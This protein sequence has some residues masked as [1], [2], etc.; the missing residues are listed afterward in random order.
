MGTWATLT[1]VTADSASVAGLARKSLMVFHHVDSLM[2]NWTGAS[3]VA[4]INREA[5]ATKIT[6]HPEVAEVLELAVLVGKQS[7][8][9]FDVTIEPLVRLWGFLG[10][11]PRVP[12]QDEIDAALEFVGPDMFDFDAGNST[13]KFSREGVK[14]D[15]GG[16]A[17]GYAVDRVAE[18]LRGAGVEDALVDLSGNMVAIGNAATHDG[19]AIGIRD[20]F[21]EFPLLAR[22]FLHDESVATSGD[23]EQFVGAGD[24]RYGHILDPRTGWSAG[25]LASVTVVTESA[26]VADAWATALF[27]LGPARARLIAKDREDL[28]VVLVEPR[29]TGEIIVWVE[30]ELRDRFGLSTDLGDAFIIHFF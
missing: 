5:A 7:R 27:V 28:A 8:S 6:I 19:W 2:S 30:E 14:I 21:G 25:G 13:V 24:K 11:T 26:A 20:P 22:I 17:K 10:G 4:R 16:I 9:A 1:L 18:L 29:E 15:F 3:E 12:S 23:Y